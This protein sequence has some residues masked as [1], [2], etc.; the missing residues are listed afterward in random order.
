QAAKS[1]KLREE[2][3]SLQTVLDTSTPALAAAQSQWEQGIKTAEGK[4]TVLEPS[5][6]VS[7]GGATLKLLPDGSVLAGGKNPDADSYEV[8]TSTKLMGITAL[9]LEVM[10][11]PSLPAGGPGRDP[12]G[13]FFLS[14]LIVEAAPADK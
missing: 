13:N 14:D 9:R 7:Q 2:I 4:W 6:F 5:H 11:D 12:N 1:K 8:S 3:A 10:S